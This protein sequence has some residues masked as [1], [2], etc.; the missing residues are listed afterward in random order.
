MIARKTGGHF[1]TV[2]A[3]NG[4]VSYAFL[5][6]N[7][8]YA[9]ST[10]VRIAAKPATSS[11]TYVLD[12]APLDDEDVVLNDVS[13]SGA[14]ALTMTGTL[15]DA[16]HNPSGGAPLAVRPDDPGW[17]LSLSGDG[18]RSVG[19]VR[20]T[21]RSRSG[22]PAPV[23]YRSSASADREPDLTSCARIR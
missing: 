1:E 6:N 18:T 23:P 17:Q 10:E 5:K 15:I 7:P 21:A 19:V 11:F 16:Q 9:D 13:R 2:V 22:R 8:A 4:G 14:I 12:P 20:R 3:S